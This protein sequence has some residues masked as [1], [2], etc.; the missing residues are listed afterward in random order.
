MHYRK[1]LERVDSPEQIFHRR[2]S[3][4]APEKCSK[5]DFL[6][7]KIVHYSVQC[8]AEKKKWEFLGRLYCT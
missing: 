5:F 3:L 2:F 4:G 8:A 1:V 6:P 7:I